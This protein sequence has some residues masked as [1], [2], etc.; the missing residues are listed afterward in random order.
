MVAIYGLFFYRRLIYLIL[1]MLKNLYII[2]LLY[3]ATTRLVP[4]VCLFFYE[5]DS[6]K[7]IL[8]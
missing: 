3:F 5:S 1:K 4:F 2:K 7:N 6:V 8:I